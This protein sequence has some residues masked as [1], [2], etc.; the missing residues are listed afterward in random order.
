MAT[1]NKSGF[2]NPSPDKLYDTPIT[3]QIEGQEFKLRRITIDDMSAVYGRIR[4]NRIKAVL[5]NQQFAQ[6]HI[7]AE[8]IAH[9]ACIDPTDDDYW[10]YVATSPGAVYVLWRC[11][12]SIPTQMQITEE[13]VMHLCEQEG[14]LI[15]LL[16]SESGMKPPAMPQPDDP[17]GE[18]RDPLATFANTAGKGK[19]AGSKQQD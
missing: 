17:E 6:P 8:A 16:L 19:E 10:N 18:N 4:D 14:G 11:M 12:H 3:V 15:N 13:Q 1:R 2:K 7:M 5:R 9:S